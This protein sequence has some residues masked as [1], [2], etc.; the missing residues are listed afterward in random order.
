MDELKVPRVER[1]I[2]LVD[3]DG[4]IVKKTAGGEKPLDPYRDNIAYL[5]LLLFN[6]ASQT[7]LTTFEGTSVPV[8]RSDLLSC[9]GKAG[10]GV[11]TYGLLIMNGSSKIPHGDGDNHL[12]YYAVSM[13]VVLEPPYITLLVQREFENKGTVDVNWNVCVFMIK[14]SDSYFPIADIIESSTQTISAGYKL[15]YKMKLRFPVT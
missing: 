12:H 10:E 4:K 15:I 6:G 5:L 8:S 3:P 7:S 14:Y 9:D 1:E 11:D 2:I 13:S